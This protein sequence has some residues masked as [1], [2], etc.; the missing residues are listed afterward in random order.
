MNSEILPW[1]LYHSLDKVI[2]YHSSKHL[3]PATS[4]RDSTAA[5]ATQYPV[6]VF[7][8][9]QVVVSGALFDFRVFLCNSEE[10]GFKLR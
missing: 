6:S 7:V 9:Y 10:K 2:Q 3:A 4:S 1:H 8:P 5:F